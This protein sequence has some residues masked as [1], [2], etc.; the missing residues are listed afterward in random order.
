MNHRPFG[1]DP[2]RV[3][4]VGL[5]TW[6]LGNEWG[7]V[8]DENA[9]AVLDEAVAQGVNFF[10]TA[11]VYGLGRSE[12]LIGR[13]LRDRAAKVFVA[14]KLG[15][16]PDPG[17]PRNFELETLRAHTEASLRRLGLEAL[18]L[19]QLHCIPPEVLR[20]GEVFEHLRSLQREGKIRRFG[21]SVESVEEGLLCLEQEGLSSLQVIFNIFRQKPADEFLG[22]ARSRGVAV[23]V[24][25]PLASGLLAGKYD[26]ST[27][28]SPE[29]HR[30]FNRDGAAFNV[31]ETFA[32]LPFETGLELV[33]ELR[34]LLPAGPPVARSAIRWCLD[35]DA[36]SV[37]I[38]GARRP[39]QV[40]ENCAAS[41][42]PPLGRE[43]HAR[44]RSFHDQKVRPH[45]RGPY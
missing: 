2:Y 18:D 8:S 28:F 6:Q 25:L 1:R 30:T 31:G 36:V 11:D 17:W 44:L 42:D 16:F 14:T 37:V 33:S 21:A 32:G 5:G 39:E 43:V 34:P 20:D 29:D 45:V 22:R 35:H 3:A 4:E 38:P 12:S 40:R 9:L 19:T 13:F 10:D 23:I 27:T 7:P 26:A 41:A 15:R 24:R